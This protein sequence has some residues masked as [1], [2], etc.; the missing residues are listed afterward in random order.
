MVAEAERDLAA[1]MADI[2]AEEADICAEGLAKC[3]WRSAK[4]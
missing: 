1:D 4:H 2:G 3:K